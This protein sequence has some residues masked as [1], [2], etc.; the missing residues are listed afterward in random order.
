MNQYL[1]ITALA[2]QTGVSSK[3]LR[4]WEALGLLP[5]AARSRAGYRFFPCEAVAYV[6]FVKKSKAIGLTLKQMQKVLRLARDGRSPCATVET[7][8]D[9]RIAELET[10]IRLLTAQLAELKCI[11]RR[12]T[13]D[14]PTDDPRPRCCSLLVGLPEERRFRRF[15][16]A[17]PV[18]RRVS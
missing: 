10:A 7:W 8:I 4:Y 11:Q 13:V 2:R 12:Y 9:A 5:K 14:A 16:Q 1:S 15:A 6:G 18:A 3:S 17:A